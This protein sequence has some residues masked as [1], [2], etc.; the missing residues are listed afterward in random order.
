MLPYLCMKSDH[1][2]KVLLSLKQIWQTE[3]LICDEKKMHQVFINEFDFGSVP[4]T[5][6]L[7]F[8]F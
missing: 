2:I 5:L 8:P 7:I 3:L 1:C 6:H 4:N